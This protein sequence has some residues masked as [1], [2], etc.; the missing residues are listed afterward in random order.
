[1]TKK[2]PYSGLTIDVDKAKY[3]FNKQADA[4]GIEQGED[5]QLARGIDPNEQQLPALRNFVKKHHLRPS[6]FEDDDLVLKQLEPRRKRLLK[7]VE[8]AEQNNYNIYGKT[9]ITEMQG[10][11]ERR[12]AESTMRHQTAKHSLENTFHAAQ[13]NPQGFEEGLAESRKAEQNLSTVNH[14]RNGAV[15]GGLAGAAGGGLLGARH[16]MQSGMGRGA[17]GTIGAAGGLL[18]AGAG[19]LGGYGAGRLANEQVTGSKYNQI[20]KPYEV[21]YSL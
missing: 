15:L 9:P 4:T 3:F 7:N 2:T 21:A 6:Q 17:V 13:R 8:E 16:A 1:M 10:D 5:R 11:R 12:R 18:A 20:K 14:D 19:A